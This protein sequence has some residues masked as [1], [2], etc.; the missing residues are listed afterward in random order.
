M[1]LYRYRVQKICRQPRVNIQERFFR[2]C[3]SCPSS[4]SRHPILAFSRRASDVKQSTIAL[5]EI[6]SHYSFEDFVHSVQ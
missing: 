6:I 1:I 2:F 5:A 3:G 4:Y